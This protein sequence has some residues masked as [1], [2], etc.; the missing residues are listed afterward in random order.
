[1]SHYLLFLH[2]FEGSPASYKAQCLK[3]YLAQNFPDIELLLPQLACYPEPA[4]SQIQ[5]ILTTFEGEIL[6]IVGASLGGLFAL[7]ASIQSQ[8]PAIVIN[9]LA[10]LSQLSYV[11]GERVHPYTG[12][13]YR[14]RQTHLETLSKLKIT[15]QQSG[16][17]HWLMLQT[18]DEVLDFRQA[19]QAYPNT[20]RTIECGGSHGFDGFARYV[21]AII[22]FLLA[23][24]E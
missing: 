2:G 24:K 6:G 8:L 10:D 22:R 14:L 16:A 15:P 1:M 5:S 7:Q 11:L 9:P 20:R 13:R 19:L 3:Q 12:E 17:Q 21:P 18:G 23:N 4:W